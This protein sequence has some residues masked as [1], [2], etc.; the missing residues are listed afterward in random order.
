MIYIAGKYTGL[1]HRHAVAKFNATRCALVAAGVPENKI[2]V[3]TDLVPPGTDWETAMYEYCIPTLLKCKAI[4]LQRDHSQSKGA[5]EELKTAKKF[6][7]DIFHEEDFGLARIASLKDY[8]ST[9]QT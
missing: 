2:I 1:D 5:M 6:R 3:P 9:D 8:M 7:M 4:F